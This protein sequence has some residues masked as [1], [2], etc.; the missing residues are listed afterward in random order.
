MCALLGAACAAAALAAPAGAAVQV[1]QSG[2]FWGNPTPQGNTLRAV[3]FL[4]GRGYAIGDAGTALRTDDGGAT[5]AG[6]PTGTSAPLS[7]LQVVTPDVLIAQGG[8]GCVIRRSDDGGKT[9]RRLYVLAESNCP[10]RVAATY[11]VT[12]QVGYIVLRDGSVLRTADAGET[13]AKQTAVPGTSASTGGGGAAPTEVVFTTADRGLVFVTVNGASRLYETTDQGVSWKP[14][15]LPGGRVDRVTLLDADNAYAVGPNLLL[16]TTDGGKTWSRRAAGDG[17]ELTSIGCATA[18]T[19]LL[20][21]AGGD[22]LLR[23]TDG[24]A[25]ATTIT[26]A[27][28]AIYAAAFA[29]PSRVVAGGAGG[30]TVVSDDGGVN[31]APV[32][33]DIGGSYLALRGGPEASIAFALGRAGQLARTNDGG[34]SWK[35]VSVPT[36]ADLADVSFD[37]SAG[38]YALDVSGGL[39]KT[40]NGGQ[41][42]Q[43]LDPGT[44]VAPRALLTPGSS[45][46]LLAGPVGVRRQ[47]GGGR[48]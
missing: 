39:F 44:T 32:G 36:S 33:S 16:R 25:T 4:S 29:S 43:T 15:D 45:T 40:A 3:D 35:A 1:S 28:Q 21:V 6:L 23:T 7:R 20:T 27:T 9:F 38:G 48:F 47:V 10:N 11:F 41:S 31:Y 34:A 17:Q 2:W 30:A 5:W 13:F 8:D 37:S 24:G 12:P 22:R 26:A 14:L 46:V 42:W 18:D 19:C